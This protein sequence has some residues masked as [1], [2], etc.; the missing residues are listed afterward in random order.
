MKKIILLFLFLGIFLSSYADESERCVFLK[1]DDYVNFFEIPYPKIKG[2]N[3]YFRDDVEY[4]VLVDDIQVDGVSVSPTIDSSVYFFLIDTYKTKFNFGNGELKSRMIWVTKDENFYKYYS[5]GNVYSVPKTAKDIKLF[6]RI[7][8][9]F[10]F[11]NATKLLQRKYSN[12]YVSELY[13]V[14]LNFAID[15]E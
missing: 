14:K 10:P 15:P 6:Y 2:R 9:P 5:F 1:H 4:V 12:T 7:V 3:R 11:G 13:S 8:Y